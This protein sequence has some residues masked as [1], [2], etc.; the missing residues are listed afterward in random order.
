MDEIKNDSVVGIVE[1]HIHTA[2]L[3]ELCIPGFQLISHKN[4]PV[5]K[6]SNT[7]PGGMA[8]FIGESVSKLVSEVGNN[9]DDTVAKN[10]ERKGNMKISI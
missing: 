6:K 1:T 10:Q 2:I 4:K 7:S 8:F 9:N 5:N 3:H